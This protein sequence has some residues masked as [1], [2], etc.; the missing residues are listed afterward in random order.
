MKKYI[1]LLIMSFCVS[2]FIAQTSQVIKKEITTE[3]KV[4]AS[5]LSEYLLNSS[6]N[7]SKNEGDIFRQGNILKDKGQEIKTNKNGIK[8]INSTLEKLSE[9]A[10]LRNQ[11]AELENQL[12]D[13]L[14]KFSDLEQTLDSQNLEL[15]SY[16]KDLE[17]LGID[18]TGKISAQ[19]DSVE[20]LKQNT[21]SLK[22]SVKETRD[23]ALSNTEKGEKNQLYIM[24]ASGVIL[25][26]LL[27]SIIIYKIVQKQKGQLDQT[28][29]QLDQTNKEVSVLAVASPV[30]ESLLEKQIEL[31]QKNA[32]GDG[33]SKEFLTLVKSL[34]DD[35]A[36]LDNV[37]YQMD[38]DARGLKHIIRAVRS[39]RNNLKVET[40]FEV[41]DI[42][43]DLV[44]VGDLIDIEISSS[45]ESLNPGERKIVRIIKP[46]ILKD[47]ELIQKPKVEIKENID[48]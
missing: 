3:G 6:N 46:K 44:R 25:L 31:S 48:G 8:A 45:D 47:G 21:D 9:I 26:L 12:N 23:S 10:T 43:G 24:I 29:G 22:V 20:N 11:N 32:E 42:I 33:N 18:L 36:K 19:V 38:P 34:A 28:K 4:D 40:G 27:I 17:K 1:V 7:I 30:I 14:G 41:P 39:Q 16:K 35:I 37:I 13:L 5:K 15:V 2:S